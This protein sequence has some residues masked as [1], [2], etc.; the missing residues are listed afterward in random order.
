MASMGLQGVN[1]PIYQAS[2]GLAQ[3]AAQMDQAKQMALVQN[4]IQ[5]ETKKTAAA[6]D[7]WS[8]LATESKDPAIQ[9]MALEKLGDY[10]GADYSGVGSR[11]DV[12]V[13]Q[14]KDIRKAVTDGGYS[15]EIIQQLID[16]HKAE[17]G[18][19]YLDSGLQ[20]QID[21]SMSAANLQKGR[22]I[23]NQ[24][25][26]TPEL[27]AQPNETLDQTMGR[28]EAYDYAQ[29]QRISA[30]NEGGKVGQNL[31]E[32]INAQEI[33]PE[34]DYTQTATLMSKKDGKAHVY[35]YNPKTDNYDI[36]LGLA[37]KSESD[38]YAD[39]QIMGRIVDKFNADPTVRKVESMDEFSQ[40]IKDAANGN[41]PIAQTAIPTLMARASGEVGNLSEADKRPFGGSQAIVERVKRIFEE[42]STG[43]NTP[44]NLKYI[45][46]LADT[47]QA[48]GVRKKNSLA[49]ERAKQYS[50][51][52]KG[53]L[54]EQDIFD[55]LSPG[56]DYNAGSPTGTGA[57]KTSKFQIIQVH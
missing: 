48:A 11:L 52:Y 57:K 5:S 12:A 8:K 29:N 56:G 16:N 40:L 35:K 25:A 28:Q 1:N 32:K 15:P 24:M 31:A 27:Q 13:S 54:S 4:A 9:K 21:K 3:Q 55:A 44:E 41:N 46:E 22:S 20:G 36:D 30:L 39:T 6:L 51:V 38:R 10:L 23:G 47:F 42:A 7:M 18:N 53:K 33:K 50:R 19:Q 37:P 34:K 49:R 14:L 43:K 26:A 45:N 2:E 17:F